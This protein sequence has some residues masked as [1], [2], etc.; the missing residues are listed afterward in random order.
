VATSLLVKL[1][2]IA[3]AIVTLALMVRIDRRASS[4]LLPRDAFSL[5]TPTGLGLWLALLLAITFSPLQIYVPIFLQR[6]HGLDPLAAGYAVTGASFGWTVASVMVAGVNEAWRGRL[7]L[8]GPLVM[9][10]GLVAVAW[11]M[12]LPP[13][14]A[15]VPAI[16]LVGVGIG[17]SWVFVAQRTMSGARPGDETVAASSVATVQQMGFAVGAALAGLVANAS[18]LEE[19]VAGAAFWVPSSFVVA[20]LIAFGAALRLRALS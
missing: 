10:A 2:L 20:A 9:G 5:S 7:I 16:V 3:G 15:V 18:G 13:G 1:A 17:I 8:F 12:P 6:L 11:L 19:G 4:P 14:Y